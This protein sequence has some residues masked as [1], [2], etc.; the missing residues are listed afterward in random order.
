MLGPLGRLI[1]RASADTQ[2]VV[3]TH[4]LPLVEHL[5]AAL[6]QDGRPDDLE[7]TELTKD[8]GE[9][10]IKDQG[11]LSRPRWEWGSR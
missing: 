6:T 2:I 4:S 9:T 3:V 7:V 11:L 1:A 5:S 8:L 10:V